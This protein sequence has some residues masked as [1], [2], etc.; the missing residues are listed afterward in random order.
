MP[1]ATVTEQ[2]ARRPRPAPKLA[3]PSAARFASFTRAP[4]ADGRR[5]AQLG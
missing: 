2:T 4:G 3:S 5:L 1:A